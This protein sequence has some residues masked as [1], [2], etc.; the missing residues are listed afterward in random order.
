MTTETPGIREVPGLIDI[1][2]HGAG[3]GAGGSGCRVS[4]QMRS[5]WR[6]KVYLGA[7]GVRLN[8]VMEAG[9]RLVIESLA[10]TL[11]ASA[12]V[13]RAVVLALD[14]VVDGSGGLDT[15]NTELYVPNDFIRAQ[16]ARFPN[17]LFGASINPLRR[18]AL[19]L[20]E[21]ESRRGAALLKWL[22]PV[23]LIDPSDK[24]FI[25]FYRK[26]ADLGLPLLTHTGF[27]RSFTVHQDEFGNP[28]RL[29]LPLECG[30]NVIAAHAGGH[31]SYGGQ[32]SLEILF[33]LCGEYENLYADISGATQINLLSHPARIANEVRLRGKLLYGS[34]MP[35]INTT[36]TTPLGFPF[37][38]GLRRVASLTRIKNPWDRDVALK[39]ALGLLEGKLLADP[40]KVL[41]LNG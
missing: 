3:L 38:L 29:R 4:T 11:A 16:T 40:A 30:V 26:M 12:R 19:D 13:G 39:E 22:P 37:K 32:R 33:G 34:D 9:D 21:F 17:L 25:P 2:C 10:D 28:A 35:L 6:F 14:G 27:E 1:H 23:Q 31:G 36:V 20:L 18:D 8:E 41:R 7:F 15:E 24:R 5:N